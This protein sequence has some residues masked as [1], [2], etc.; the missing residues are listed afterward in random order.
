MAALWIAGRRRGREGGT[1]I[2][3]ISRTSLRLV[4]ETRRGQIQPS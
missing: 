3:H 2:H 4:R 1:V